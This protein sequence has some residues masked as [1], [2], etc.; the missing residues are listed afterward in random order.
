MRD[1]T[2]RAIDTATQAG[3]SYADIRIEHRRRQV[4]SVKNSSLDAIS[5]DRTQGFGVRALVNG[6]WGFASSLRLEPAEVDRVARLAV[7]IARASAIASR[8]PIDMGPAI[9]S[10]GV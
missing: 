2:Q 1:L 3:A 9:K 7:D 4:I 6:A 5:N 8:R 10:I